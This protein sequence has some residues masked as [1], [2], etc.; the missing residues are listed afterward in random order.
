MGENKINTKKFL[1]I[2]PFRKLLNWSVQYLTGSEIEFTAA[3]SMVRIG[4]FLN[5]NK[6]PITIED[7]KEYVRVKIKTRNGGVERR[8]KNNVLGKNIGTKKQFVISEGQFIVSKID[9]RNGAMGI[10]PKELDGAIVTQDF[11]PYDIDSDIIN[12]QYLVL[13]STTKPFVD[14]C[15][16]CS[17]GTT[18]RQ[19]INEDEF[20]NIRIPVPDLDNQK[21]LVDSYME[22][23]T[24]AT[25][26][27]VESDKT[28]RDLYA[29]LLA[30]L[31]IK[32]SSPRN[33]RNILRFVK[34]HNLKKWSIDEIQKYA[35]Y[36]FENSKYNVVRIE[37]IVTSFEGGKTPSTKRADYW[38]KDVFWVSAKDM[39]ELYLLNIQDK[40]TKKGVD[41][42]KLTVYP[43]GTILGVFRSGI[44]RHSFP[45]CITAHPVTINQ[46]LKAFCI[47]EKKTKKLYFL[48]YIDIMQDMVLNIARKKGVT[49]E[50]INADAFMEIPFVCPPMIVQSEIVRYI[51][52]KKK[53]IYQQLEK[54]KQ[55]R[56]QAITDFE[57]KIYK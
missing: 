17:S 6:T 9:A 53:C 16:S 19:R 43:K 45:I 54:A 15:Q 41:E 38:G 49:V 48:F 57:S 30:Q 1:S 12:P 40:L 11:L 33:I 26:L 13:I 21:L 24:K 7:K 22:N 2:V 56:I 14:F 47:D 35:K 29:W 23:I 4:D 28:K 5:R 39:K 32:E 31:N 3:Y 46:D 51:Y 37:D 55:L 8:E 36:S 50:S 44:L 52:E 27:E 42:T 25:Q 18:N 34:Y 10:V 20:L